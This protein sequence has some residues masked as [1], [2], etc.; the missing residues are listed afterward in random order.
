[1]NARRSTSGS[2]TMPRSYRPLFISSIMPCRFFSKGSGL[3]AKS[4]LGSPLMSLHDTFSCSR[5]FGSI[6]PPTELIVS[7]QTLKRECFIASRSTYFNCSTASMCFWSKE[8]SSMYLPKWSTSAY[9]KFSSSAS[10]STSLPSSLLRNSPSWLSSFS[11]FHCR[12]L[13]LAVIMIP[14]SAFAMLTASS[15]VGVV[16][17]PMFITS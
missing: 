17:S 12:G 15:V 13:W 14:P 2:T 1:M 11:A 3:W 7:T 9:S 5:S 8:L 10:R 4:P 16:A 6:T